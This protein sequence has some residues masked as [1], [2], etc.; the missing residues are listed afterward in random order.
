MAQKTQHREMNLRVSD[1]FYDFLYKNK[2]S[3]RIAR[4]LY[5]C[6]NWQGC[7]DVTKLFM[8][9]EHVNYLT[10]R[11]DGTISYLPK[12]KEHVVN[13]GRW[14]R[15]NR[16]NGRPATII[17]KLLTPKAQMLFKDT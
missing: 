2:E 4:V 1:S 14:A 7:Y 15:D 3:N 11:G 17:K 10:L 9:T 12:G 13:D 16:Q 6:I 8:T 5:R